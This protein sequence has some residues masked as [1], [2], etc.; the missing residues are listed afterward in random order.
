[1]GP[2]KWR[3]ILW[4][5]KKIKERDKG[6]SVKSLCIKATMI[7]KQKEGILARKFGDKFIL[8]AVGDTADEFHSLITVNETGYFIWNEL[9]DGISYDDL[10]K[11]ITNTYEIDTQTAEKDLTEFLNSARDAG[12]I[13]EQ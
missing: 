6:F 3:T 10:L 5:L 1:M 13:Y 12:L 4:L 9:K 2:L 7:I 11:H 8:V